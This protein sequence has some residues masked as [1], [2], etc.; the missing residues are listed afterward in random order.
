M[1]SI[2]SEKWFGRSWRRLWRLQAPVNL[3]VAAS[4]VVCLQT[5]TTAARPSQTRL[6]HRN[7]FANGRRYYVYPLEAGF[8][9]RSDSKT[10]WNRRRRTARAAILDAEVIP[11]GAVTTVRI[12]SRMRVAY[13]MLT[14][15]LP[16]WMASIVVFAPWSPALTVAI[17]TTLFGL[18]LASSRLDAALQAHDMIYFVRTALEDL[19][20]GEIGI[21]GA[22]TDV[23]INPVQREFAQ[24]W[25]RFYDEMQ[26]DT[27]TRASDPK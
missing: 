11:A 5:I 27:T 25:A 15:L 10:V 8:E 23:I 17:V 12:H 3:T 13:F 9:L 19:P 24:E 1:A 21:L 2:S 16:S 7:L 14:L 18:A 4:P 6:H 20:P 26:T 22:R